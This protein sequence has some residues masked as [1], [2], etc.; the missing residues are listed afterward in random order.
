VDEIRRVPF[1]PG[2]ASADLVEFLAYSGLRKSEAANV[3]WGDCNMTKREILVRGDPQTGTK[4]TEVRR[5]PMIPDMVGLLD[6]LQEEQ[7]DSDPGQAVMRV[8][9][10][11]GAL[12][13]AWRAR[14]WTFGWSS[15]DFTASNG[16]RTG[17][18]S[19]SPVAW[20]GRG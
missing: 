10:C 16:A 4:N 3:T 17:N 1:G 12:T 8:K 7:D 18:N 9:K 5:V 20:S 13:K 6:R 15:G 14:F 2:L 11:Q 19:R